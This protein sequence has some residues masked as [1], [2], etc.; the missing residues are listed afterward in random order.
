MGM[1]SGNY[2]CSLPNSTLSDVVE[3][4]V[5][6]GDHFLQLKSP[7]TSDASATVTEGPLSAVIAT[8]MLTK[9]LAV[10]LPAS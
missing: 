9:T 8:V 4:S 5:Q 1:D 6:Q 2:S 10:Y 7:D 3:V